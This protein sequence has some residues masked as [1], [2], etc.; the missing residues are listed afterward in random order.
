MLPNRT[1]PN[2]NRPPRFPSIADSILQGCH[3]RDVA[4]TDTE[5]RDE[6][7]RSA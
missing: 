7:L 4:T 5:N 3:L 6:A 1:H 2:A